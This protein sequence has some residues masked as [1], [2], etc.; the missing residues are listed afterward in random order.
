MRDDLIK[1]AAEVG[2][3]LL[4]RK[5]YITTAESCTGG[6]VS[7]YLTAIPGGSQWFD[8]GFITYSNE[9]KIE[10][11]GVDP[12]TIER[13]GAVSKEV[14]MEMAEGALKH[15]MADI[16]VAITGIAGPE[17]GSAD[18]PVGTVWIAWN[19]RGYRAQASVEIFRGDRHAVRE[20]TIAAALRGVQELL[21]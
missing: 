11:I 17:G 2:K 1:L 15:S 6:G 12:A 8:R 20:Q 14:A 3:A 19:R 13:F 21:P 7:Y 9:A 4:T 10:Q 16:S 5:I 18:K